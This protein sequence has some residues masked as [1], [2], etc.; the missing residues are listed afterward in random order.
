MLICDN[1][2]IAREGNIL[3][4]D[5]GFTLFPGA[6]L[7]LQGSNGAGKTSLL[8]AIAGIREPQK[9][10]MYYDTRVSYLGHKLAIKPQLTIAENLIFWSS[11]YESELMISAALHY[12]QLQDYVDTPC[13]NLSA[14]M[15]KRVSLA[16]I[17]S[18]ASNIWLLDEPET[19]LDDFA[20]KRLI[21]MVEIESDTQY[22]LQ[23]QLVELWS[24][25]AK[26]HSSLGKYVTRIKLLE[27]KIQQIRDN[28]AK[29]VSAE[30]YNAMLKH[31][32]ELTNNI[33]KLINSEE[34]FQKLKNELIDLT[35]TIQT[36]KQLREEC[37]LIYEEIEN[38]DK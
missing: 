1:L 2:T 31:S 34:D 11:L 35:K 10:E 32:K 24:Q 30:E 37:K 38:Y 27:Q 13:K 18:C 33:S 21:Q 17:M 14:G 23:Q 19:N 25:I 36:Q 15:L 20:K 9:G 5:V 12:F 8:E 3:L 29:M 7:V 6:L 4:K 26:S 28:L 16:R 22:K